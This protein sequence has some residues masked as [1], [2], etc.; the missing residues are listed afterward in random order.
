[1]WVLVVMGCKRVEVGEKC[2]KFGKTP[3]FSQPARTRLHCYWYCNAQHAVRTL[4]KT[5]LTFPSG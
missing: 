1:L 4:N 2:P 3:Y 5:N